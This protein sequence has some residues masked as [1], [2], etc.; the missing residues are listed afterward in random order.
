MSQ[1]DGAVADVAYSLNQGQK[2]VLTFTVE[3]SDPVRL[4]SGALQWAG[5]S[6]EPKS[7]MHICVFLGDASGISPIPS[8]AKQYDAESL[9]RLPRDIDEIAAHMVRLMSHY[10]AP[11]TTDTVEAVRMLAVATTDWPKGRDNTR[12]SY[13][14]LARLIGDEFGL[15]SAE[16]TEDGDAGT[17]LR[18]SRKVVPLDFI[19]GDELFEGAL[20]RLV[21]AKGGRIQLSSEHRNYPFI[22]RLSSP[23]GGGR[24]T[25]DIWFDVDKSNISQA[26]RFWGLV[27]AIESSEAVTLSGPSGEMAV[28]TLD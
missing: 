3:D 23:M 19:G 16:D 2:P 22:F 18:P 24:S 15:F 5:S 26:L 4:I 14:Y 6:T 10:S 8:T 1:E 11:E 7:W 9:G 12:L 17:I 27:E 21:E 28:L 25:L 20:L 13:A